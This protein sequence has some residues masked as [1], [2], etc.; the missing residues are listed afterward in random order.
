MNR[1]ES[2]H[3]NTWQVSVD[4]MRRWMPALPGNEWKVVLAIYTRSYSIFRLHVSMEFA[5]LMAATGLT[6]PELTEAL[7]RLRTRGAL[8]M[9]QTGEV[10][11]DVMLCDDW[12]PEAPEVTR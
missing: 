7:C 9:S 6:V 5:E 1:W 4:F 2:F 8:L 12:Q 10:S 11:F 3:A